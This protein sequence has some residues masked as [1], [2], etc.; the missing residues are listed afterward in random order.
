MGGVGGLGVGK[1][2]VAGNHRR[3]RGFCGGQSG[4]CTD[5]Q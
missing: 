3:G 2:L 5:R 1:G 4:G